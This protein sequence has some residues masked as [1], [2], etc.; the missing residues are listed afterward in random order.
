MTRIGGSKWRWAFLAALLL[1]A[2][3]WSAKSK[4]EESRDSEA[5]MKKDIFFLASPQCEGRGPTTKGLALAADH[6]AAGFEKAG[7]KPGTKDGYF[8]PFTIPAAKGKLALVGPGDKAMTLTQGKD[9]NP[10]GR[11]QKGKAEAGVVFAGFGVTCK[12]PEYDD[13]AGIDVKDK[14]VVILRDTPGA[15]SAKRTPAMKTAGS[16]NAKLVLAKKKG[17]VGVL[18]V[19]DS[20]AAAGDDT[21]L[22]FSYAPMRGSEAFMPSMLV[23]RDLVEKMLPAG[24]T[25]ADLEK[26]I[27]K[28]MK[29][30]SFAIEGWKVRLE[31]ELVKTAIPL[32]NVI[33]VLEGAGPLAKETVIVGSHYDHLGYGGPSSLAA[34][35][36]RLIHFGA[37]DNASGTT[38]VMEL[39]RRYA[40]MPNRQGRRLVFMAFSGEELGLL[41]SKYYCENPIFPLADTVAMFNIDM[42]GRLSPDAKTKLDKVLTEGHGTAKPFEAMIGTAA[43]E[44]GF[45]L[46]SKASGRGPSD[47]SSFNDKGIPVLFVWTGTHPD[48]HRPTDTPDKINIAGMRRIADASQTLITKLTTMERPAYIKLKDSRGNRPSKGPRLG[49]RPAYDED[50]KGVKIETV[51]EG[52]IAERDGIKKGDMIVSIAGKEVKSLEGYMEAMAAT[53]PGTTIEVIVERAA[54]KVT[55]KVKL[56]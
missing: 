55:L 53:K 6:V 51:V 31:S 7:L 29:P 2:P 50:V 56:E 19:N 42:V 1:S 35:K 44:F 9:F 37:D 20:E 24:K 8:Q 34:T 27:T 26:A 17:A 39:A 41:G 38:S 52:G 21:P 54:K 23:R 48:Y 12:T 47:H 45:V 36:K 14:V 15:A 3:A 49:I 25:F 10:L 33:G 40:A 46:S 28:D 4:E 13:Y 11:N 18:M 43:K 16:L 22:D 30:D 32:K 5:R